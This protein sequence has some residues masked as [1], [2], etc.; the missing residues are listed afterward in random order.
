MRR[1][2]RLVVLT[3][4]ATAPLFFAESARADASSWAVIG[5]GASSIESADLPAAW[6]GTM[7]LD[8][9]VGTTPDAPV[10]FGGLF[11]IA[12]ILGEGSDLG[13]LARVATHGYQAGGFGVAADVGV[14]GRWWGTDSSGF[15][16]GLTLG[17]P[18]GLTL[19]AVATVGSNDA[20]GYGATLG[21][22]LLRLTVYRQST[23]DYWPNPSPAQQ[24]TAGL[25]SLRF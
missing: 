14:Y 10:I 24:V 9:G 13:A 20:L 23:L 2:A 22:D 16:G 6:Y 8:V 7:Q 18:F 17:A 11:R 19:G 1:P 3:F 12:P 21:I 4:A 25:G 5:G 15:Q